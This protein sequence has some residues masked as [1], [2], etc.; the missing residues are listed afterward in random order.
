MILGWFFATKAW[1]RVGWTRALASIA[2][3][4]GADVAVGVAVAALLGCDAGFGVW[5]WGRK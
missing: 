4:I 5:P 1:K 3:V 2:L